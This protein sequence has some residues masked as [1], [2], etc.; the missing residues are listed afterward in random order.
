M[1]ETASLENGARVAVL[2]PGV[3]GWR[4]AALTAHAGLATVLDDLFPS[5]PDRVR[6]G[7]LGQLQEQAG[8]L[9]ADAAAVA[10][11]MARITFAASMEDAVRTADLA[12]DCVPD[13]LE[14]KLEALSLLDRMAPPHTIFC[15]PTRAL[16]IADL[17]SC[18]YRADRCV[19]VWPRAAEGTADSLSLTLAT[20]VVLAYTPQ[21]RPEALA[22]AI[23]F[24]RQLGK[25]VTTELDASA[26]PPAVPLRAEE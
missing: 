16:G 15:T 14:S 7:V 19:A 6:A 1:T 24:W 3:A 20:D 13:E 12:L 4:L 8:R 10:A 26:T 17:A 21:T 22:T 18:T 11:A 5:G 2:G 23:A 9:H 25:S